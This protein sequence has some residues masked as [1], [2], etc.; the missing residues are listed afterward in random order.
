MKKKQKNTL[1]CPV[2]NGKKRV[3]F[4]PDK[5]IYP[6]EA[7]KYIAGYDAKTD[8][9]KCGNCGGQ[10]M[11]GESTGRVPANIDGNPCVHE[12]IG[13]ST[14]RCLSTLTC[15]HCGDIYHIDSGD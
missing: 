9:L 7:R 11:Y 8:T 10:Y 14:G 4:F 5:Y 1:I 15:K 2:C 3:P 6:D 13:R 12:Y